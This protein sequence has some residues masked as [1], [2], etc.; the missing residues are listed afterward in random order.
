MSL[1]ELSTLA[2]RLV[3]HADS[4]D[5][6]TCG[7]LVAD[8][9]LA[10]RAIGECDRLR[11]EIR[12][13]ADSTSDPVCRHHLRELLGEPLE[14]ADLLVDVT[15]QGGTTRCSVPLREAVGDDEEEYED[16]CKTLLA[17]GE[18]T[19]GGGDSPL[20]RLTLV[21]DGR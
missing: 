3:D 8:L 13:A 16:C 18:C 2:R 9:W 4:I 14:P 20:Y 12:R 10:S 11:S 17:D 1:D 21:K 15:D 6:V 7:P 5:N 19:R